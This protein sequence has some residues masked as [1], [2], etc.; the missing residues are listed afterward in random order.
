MNIRDVKPS[1]KLE[2]KAMKDELLAVC[3]QN[4]LDN[5]LEEIVKERKEKDSAIRSEEHNQ[6]ER[7]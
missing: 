1:H 3:S 4:L 5:L 7:E 2:A 6:K